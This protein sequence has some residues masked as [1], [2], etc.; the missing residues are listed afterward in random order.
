MATDRWEK[1]PP[2]RTA[3]TS[4]QH[5]RHTFRWGRVKGDPRP[6]G[7]VCDVSW[8]YTDNAGSDGVSRAA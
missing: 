7:E 6:A 4:R 3:H 1:Q 2:K 8:A 5:F